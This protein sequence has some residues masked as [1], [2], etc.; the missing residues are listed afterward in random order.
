MKKK[1]VI[2]RSSRHGKRS[3]GSPIHP[4]CYEVAEKFSFMRSD[5]HMMDELARL[6]GGTL[7][8]DFVAFANGNIKDLQKECVIALSKLAA[9]T[10]NPFPQIGRLVK[11][12]AKRPPPP[13][14]TKI[15]LAYQD[16]LR[17]HGEPPS[18]KDL[19]YRLF[20]VNWTNSQEAFARKVARKEHL[21]LKRLS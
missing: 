18:Y 21:P 12:M 11:K 4:L 2:R 17:D 5:F 19:C 13:K 14:T 8:R 16:H 10:G 1:K 20:G 7:W 9:G 15:I 3:K 6:D